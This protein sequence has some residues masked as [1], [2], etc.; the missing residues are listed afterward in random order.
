MVALRFQISILNPESATMSYYNLLHLL[1]STAL[2]LSQRH[3][4]KKLKSE[5]Y[6]LPLVLISKK[7]LD[8]KSLQLSMEP[9]LLLDRCDMRIQIGCIL[10]NR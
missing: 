3:L 5:T 1:I 4:F 8:M 9:E 10:Q 7:S 6:C 2:I